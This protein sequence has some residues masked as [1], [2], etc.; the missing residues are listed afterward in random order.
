MLN[1]NRQ[2]KTLHIIAAA[3]TSDMQ[4][5]GKSCASLL[6]PLGGVA[7]LR[8]DADRA[9]SSSMLVATLTGPV[10]DELC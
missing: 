1:W 10:R 3:D 6:R 8:P 7:K 2:R 9:N 5:L 4:P